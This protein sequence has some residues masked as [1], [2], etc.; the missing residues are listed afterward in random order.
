M[1]KSR[2]LPLFFILLLVL[3]GPSFAASRWKELTTN[4]PTTEGTVKSIYMTSLTSG[5]AVGAKVEFW[6]TSN[7]GQSWAS[8]EG[9]A[10]SN[11]LEKVRFSKTD[12]NLGFAGGGTGAG[13]AHIYRTTDGGT[14]WSTIE[15]YSTDS[16]TNVYT[17]FPLGANNVW[18][19][20]YIMG[21]ADK[22]IVR[23]TTGG[24]SGS[25]TGYGWGADPM[26]V[27]DL[28]FTDANR[29][30]AVG[31][32]RLSLANAGI[33]RA[34]TGGVTW[35]VVYT[36]PNKILRAVEFVN[37]NTGWAVGE[38]VTLGS[39]KPLILKTTNG[40]ALGGWASYSGLP[41]VNNCFYGISF[42]DANNGWVVG[43]VKNVYRTTDAGGTWTSN[44]TGLGG[45]GTDNYYSVYF[46]DQYN[47]WLA[48]NYYDGVSKYSPKIYKW[49]VD[50]DVSAVNQS[51]TAITNI[52][53]GY[54]GNIDITGIN[55]RPDS[56]ISFGS[57]I[58]LNSL[59]PVTPTASL[60]ALATS[61]ASLRANITVANAAASGARNMT[62]SNPDT[63]VA[64]YS[65]F[66]VSNKP[67]IT[68][69]SATSAYQGWSGTL[70]IT[71][72]DF[73][74]GATVAMGS[75]VNVLSTTY[76]SATRLESVVNVSST[77]TPGFVN[78]TVTNP[79][80]GV[81]AASFE[82]KATTNPPVISSIAFNG[83][84]YV[85]PTTLEVT[86][87][88]TVSFDFAATSGVSTE[89]FKIYVQSGT[90]ATKV[91]N[92]PASAYSVGHVSYGL[93]GALTA[94]YSLITV[95]GQDLAG[96]GDS[97]ACNVH[98]TSSQQVSG[99]LIPYPNPW[100]PATDPVLIIQ[101]H[102]EGAVSGVAL[103]AIN[104]A[105]Q[106]TSVS[107]ISLNAGYN[108]INYDSR[109]YTSRPANGVMGFV[110]TK[111]NSRLA[112]GAVVVNYR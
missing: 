75:G 10:G 6:K 49:V 38:D 109:N 110:L 53:Q 107:N 61:Y 81:A 101:A 78:V 106:V 11:V 99:S 40:G 88:P 46:A 100:N 9:I 29:G 47:G 84:A 56:T 8:V 83:T 16:S 28:W 71:G 62:V 79:D 20:G 54:S 68:N 4:Y 51:G 93:P 64:T 37:S 12:P 95:Y 82:V 43:N 26:C 52:P 91:Y 89:G 111:N 2:I 105:G 57:G 80:N 112:S 14:T 27:Y 5:C 76:V 33:R 58:T 39:E 7:G 72:T 102:S 13:L 97:R 45:A 35:E 103:N 1:L 96:A 42:A 108:N 74:S 87:N 41:T 69:L 3:T 92:L 23:S 65:A 104:T 60:K 94:G 44:V 32:D 36:D 17:V 73:V 59:T 19:G 50:P 77:A 34:S 90:A 31:Y 55:L 30:F 70:V 21:A 25:F 15:T 63:G 98:Y 18:G 22:Q 48:G 66:S 86:A 67:E 24:G 85:A